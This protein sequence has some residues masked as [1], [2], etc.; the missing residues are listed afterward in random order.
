MDWG[1][2]IGVGVVLIGAVALIIWRE[3]VKEQSVSFA[4]FVQ[5]VV[6]ET[7]KITWPSRDELRK[8]TIAILV[9]VVI[10]AVV[11]GT[12]DIVLQWL[13]VRLPSSI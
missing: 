10:V 1:L 5:D 2:Y 4:G 11:I 3:T 9:F 6:A 8:W 12:M 13:L 7:K